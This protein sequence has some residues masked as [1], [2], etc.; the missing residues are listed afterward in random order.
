MEITHIQIGL[1]SDRP[2]QHSEDKNH[3][4]AQGFEDGG[5]F[6]YR[7]KGVT[8]EVTQAQ[9]ARV[10]TNPWLNYFSTALLLHQRVLR[11]GLTSEGG[12]VGEKNN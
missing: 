12:K 1:H 4:V 10:A 5:K 11:A 2:G 8:L 9:L 7:A 3:C 6:Y